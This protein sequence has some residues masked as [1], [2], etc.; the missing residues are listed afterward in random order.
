MWV[1]MHLYHQQTLR[2]HASKQQSIVA[3]LCGDVLEQ[4]HHPISRLMYTQLD[5]V[6]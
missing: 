1:T 2:L 4:T 3:A 5:V 6:D